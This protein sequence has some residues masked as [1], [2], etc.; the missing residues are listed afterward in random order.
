MQP[1]S[2]TWAALAIAAGAQRRLGGLGIVVARERRADTKVLVTGGGGSLR[3]RMG[4]C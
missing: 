1:A 3:M 2:R 4:H